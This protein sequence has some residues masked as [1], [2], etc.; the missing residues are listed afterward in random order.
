MTAPEPED[1]RDLKRACV[2]RLGYSRVTGVAT[3]ATGKIENSGN[4]DQVNR[5]SQNSNTDWQADR[6]GRVGQVTRVSPNSS[7]DR[8]TDHVSRVNWVC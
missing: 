5:V 2:V 3:K 4:H 6:V 1:K 7:T 8:W